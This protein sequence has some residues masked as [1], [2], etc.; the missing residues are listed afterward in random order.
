MLRAGRRKI[1]QASLY[2]G[3]MSQI[4]YIREQNLNSVKSERKKHTNIILLGDN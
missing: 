3:L 4:L 1:E 2:Y